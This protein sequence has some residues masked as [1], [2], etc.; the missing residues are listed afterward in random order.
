[1][2]DFYPRPSLRRWQWWPFKASCS[3]ISCPFGLKTLPFLIDVLVKWLGILWKVHKNQGCW[4]DSNRN[5]IGW[6]T[7][8][9]C[10][11]TRG[12]TV[13]NSWHESTE[14]TVF[15]LKGCGLFSPKFMAWVRTDQRLPV[16]CQAGPD[17]K[18]VLKPLG[19]A[20]TP[21]KMIFGDFSWMGLG[22]VSEARSVWVSFCWK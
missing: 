3:Y 14:E 22:M 1:M 21:G 19:L 20:L 12:S 15:N 8:K 9:Q 4:N 2:V 13:Q 16:V 7:C 5:K 6:E 18:A 11:G 17:V 10:F